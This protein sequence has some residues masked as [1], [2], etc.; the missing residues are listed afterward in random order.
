MTNA[1]LAD[2]KLGYEVLNVESI[3]GEKLSITLVVSRAITNEA[4]SQNAK[5]IYKSFF[6]P[7]FK[8]IFIDWYLPGME[9]GSGVW[10]T[11][12]FNPRLEVK[13]MTWML[14]HNPPTEQIYAE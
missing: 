1:I 8:R 5:M 7:R 12:H 9:I 10:A 2:E 11:T 6:G 14:K 4:L 13:I 3:P